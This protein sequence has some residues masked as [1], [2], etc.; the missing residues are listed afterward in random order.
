[1]DI[2]KRIEDLRKQKGWSIYKLAEESMVTQSTLANMYTRN[3]MPS[4]STLINI[5]NGL[6]ISL[7][8][9]FCENDKDMIRIKE[10]K[11][12]QSYNKLTDKQKDAVLCLI[13]NLIE[14]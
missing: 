3:T 1:M 9:F 2:L 7:S 4:I 11:L 10:D 14:E 5:C 12:L 6:G 13:Q 8:E